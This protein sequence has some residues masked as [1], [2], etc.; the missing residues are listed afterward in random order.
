MGYA[1][2][3]F[4]TLKAEEV[5]RNEYQTMKGAI[6]SVS[7]FID[8]VY[9]KERLHSRLGYRSPLEFE[10]CLQNEAFFTSRPR[11]KLP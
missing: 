2:S 5:L 6:E 1:E 11:L 4:K 9:N 8:Q 7:L 3:F 10:A